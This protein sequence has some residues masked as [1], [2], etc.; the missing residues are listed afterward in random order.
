MARR[1]NNVGTP[2][3]TIKSPRRNKAFWQA[4]RHN[5]QVGEEKKAV[6]DAM[7]EGET[8]A[9]RSRKPELRK[10]TT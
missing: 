6:H 10:R 3:R 8:A 9:Y 5:Q 2:M 7:I 1:E 4:I